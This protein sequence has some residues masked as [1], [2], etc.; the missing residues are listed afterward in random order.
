LEGVW[1]MPI[2]ATGVEASNAAETISNGSEGEDNCES[3]SELGVDR[4]RPVVGF[5]DPEGTSHD[6][7]KSKGEGAELAR[8]A[9][10]EKDRKDEEDDSRG[11]KY[12]GSKRESMANE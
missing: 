12:P 8:S 7:V 5:L 10:E 11:S 6:E 1:K 2:S 9:K 3:V 4:G